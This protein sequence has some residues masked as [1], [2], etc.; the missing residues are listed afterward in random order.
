[1]NNETLVEGFEHIVRR[2]AGPTARRVIFMK[3]EILK[4]MNKGDCL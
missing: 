3:R 1:M 4:R 2:G